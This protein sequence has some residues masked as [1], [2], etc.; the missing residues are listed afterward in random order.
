MV[1]SDDSTTN[2]FVA[3]ED[4]GLVGWPMFCWE[5]LVE[6]IAMAL[7]G[8]VATLIGAIAA[9]SCSRA[10]MEFKSAELT[11]RV[12]WHGRCIE[13]TYKLEQGNPVVRRDVDALSRGAGDSDLHP[14][15]ADGSR[16]H[17]NRLAT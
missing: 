6:S 7:I 10:A 12:E 15:V 1:Y 17:A 9:N 3:A 4:N 2:R 8:G 5:A 11:P 13:H 16:F 14:R